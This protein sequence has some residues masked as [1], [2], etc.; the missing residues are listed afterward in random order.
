MAGRTLRENN[1]RVG[2]GEDGERQDSTLREDR[3]VGR[4]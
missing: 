1:W 4:G 2:R 3:R